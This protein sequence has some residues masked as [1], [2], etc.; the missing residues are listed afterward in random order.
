MSKEFQQLLDEYPENGPSKLKKPELLKTT[1]D[2]AYFVDYVIKE[3][4]VF[5]SIAEDKAKASRASLEKTL[6]A[7]I[8]VNQDIEKLSKQIETNEEVSN[9][10]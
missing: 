2:L 8:Q 4:F 7:Y 3:M 5:A 1:A 6:T 9:E 10:Q